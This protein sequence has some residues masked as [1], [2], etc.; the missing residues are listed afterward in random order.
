MEARGWTELDILIISGDAYVDHPAFGPVLIARFLEARGFKVGFIAQPDW[1]SERDVMRMGRP[2][3][4]VGI[5]AGNL[6]SMLNKLTAQKKV[7]SEDFYSPGGRPGARPN[8]A[9]VVYSNL[10]RGAMPGVP[11]VL[12]G[13]EA[14]LRRI[15]HFDYWSDKVRRSVLL[16]SKADL[17]I[18]G[19]GER[20]VWEVARRLDAG[21]PITA[22]R[23]VRGT[24]HVLNKGEWEQLPTSRFVRDGQVVMLPSYEQVRDDRAAFSEMSRVF[25]YE[26]N[27]G[28]ARP[29]LQAHGTQAV[30]FNPPA[31]PLETSDMDELYD[32]P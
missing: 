15:A 28:N 26:T 20:P 27:P 31:L 23:D 6:D 16:D 24:A 8:R 18:F 17:L 11:I 14:S 5:S 3:L 30:Y 1:S 12:G 2:R 9:S 10:L 4:F 29:L 21:E 19:M 13:I 22:I 32:L 25:Q 7:R